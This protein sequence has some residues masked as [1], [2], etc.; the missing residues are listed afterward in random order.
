MLEKNE[1]RT[2]LWFPTQAPTTARGF[3]E[4]DRTKTAI[5]GIVIN[6]LST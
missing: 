3:R 5:A 6:L 1:G 4:N 2:P